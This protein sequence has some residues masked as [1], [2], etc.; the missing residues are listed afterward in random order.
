[1]ATDWLPAFKHEDIELIKETTL[2]NN[3]LT[4][5]EYSFKHKLFYGGWS[6]TL[7]R[8][9]L[10]KNPAVMVLLYDP[11]KDLIIMVEQIRMGLYNDK[12]SPWLL[13]PV[14]GVVEA[15]ESPQ[16]TAIRETKEESD[17]EILDLEFICEYYPSPGTS[18]E[19]SILYC[20]RVAA[21]ESGG[22]YGL[23]DEGEDIKI[24]I[25]SSNLVFKLLKENKLNN[26]SAIISV[27]WL[28]EHK[29]DLI[30][31]WTKDK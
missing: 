6:K 27:M 29:N 21:P 16:E 4:I 28:K 15:G 11:I 26:A 5:K 2:F 18:S 25:L 14:A 1:M 19:K 9:L 7:T 24:H 17:C 3:Y 31:K 12:L 30:Q 23:I 20:G 13:E 10:V 22:C 8:E